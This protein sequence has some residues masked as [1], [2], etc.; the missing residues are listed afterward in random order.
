M[1]DAKK[2]DRCGAF[3]EKYYPGKHGTPFNGLDLM[4]FGPRDEEYLAARLEL[5]PACADYLCAVLTVCGN[6]PPKEGS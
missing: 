2:C 1:A 3:Y 6:L 5:C 4:R